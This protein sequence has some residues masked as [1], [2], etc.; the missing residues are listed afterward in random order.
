IIVHLTREEIQNENLMGHV[1]DHIHLE[2]VTN[3]ITSVDQLAD[4]LHT[5][6]QLNN[7][8]ARSMRINRRQVEP[9]TPLARQISSMHTLPEA[10]AAIQNVLQIENARPEEGIA[11]MRDLDE[12]AS[13]R[14]LRLIIR[15]SARE[16][17]V[18]ETV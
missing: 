14:C 6:L 18:I 2:R 10:A 15:S 7:N 5:V 3:G 8:R 9:L 4:S 16:P 1:E 17:V 12:A 11:V 13:R